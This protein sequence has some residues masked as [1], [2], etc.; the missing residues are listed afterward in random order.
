MR[1][2]SSAIFSSV[3]S[4][5][6]GPGRR[7]RPRAVRPRRSRR[8]PSRCGRAPAM[9]R[10]APGRRRSRAADRRRR[11]AARDSVR[12][13]RSSRW[14]VAPPRSTS[15]RKP[16][17]SNAATTA[18]EVSMPKPCMP[19]QEIAHGLLGAEEVAEDR[20]FETEGLLSSGGVPSRTASSRC[21]TSDTA[22]RRSSGCSRAACADSRRRGTRRRRA[23]SN[24]RRR[25]CAA[26]RARRT[27]RAA[28]PVASA[29]G[30]ESGRHGRGGRGR[31][32]QPVEDAE[33][34]GGEH[35][36]RAAESLDQ[37]DDGS[38]IG[39]AHR[40]SEMVV[41]ERRERRS[42]QQ[43]FARA[44]FAHGPDARQRDALERGGHGAC[45]RVNSN[46]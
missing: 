5:R 27:R 43:D 21:P 10:H 11:R 35:R 37:I 34:D 4:C 13:P 40:F 22:P 1:S 31:V 6:I 2:S 23:R 44:A 29:C 39:Q 38:G 30:F 14:P 28:A 16:P 36:L 26:G 33:R 9:R 46:S 45:E 18:G 24:R 8:P 25:A 12:R 41:A 17:R 3:Q 42:V 15:V 20:A 7:G 19:Q 32:V